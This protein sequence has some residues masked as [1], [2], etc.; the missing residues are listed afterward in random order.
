MILIVS[1][2]AVKTLEIRFSAVHFVCNHIQ[3]DVLPVATF[4]LSAISNLCSHKLGLQ[5]AMGHMLC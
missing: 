4:F 5:H 1:S 2:V 3:G